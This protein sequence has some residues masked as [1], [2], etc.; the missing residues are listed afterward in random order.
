MRA[1]SS[2][3][4]RRR[5][6]M[7]ASFVLALLFAGLPAS[8]LQAQTDLAKDLLRRG[9]VQRGVCAVV[10]AR[11]DLALDL[12]SASELSVLVREPS[13]QRVRGLRSRAEARGIGIRRLVVDQGP[14]SRLPFADNMVDLVIAAEATEETLRSLS[15]AEVTRA[16]RPEG[17]AIVGSSGSKDGEDGVGAAEL[18]AWAADVAGAQ[19]R[20]DSSGVWIEFRKPPLEGADDWSHWE[21]GPDNNPVS[22]DQV[23]KAPYMTQFLQKPFYIGM[24]SVTTAAGGR[25]FLAIGH[26]AHH[27]REWGGLLRLMARNGYNG[28]VLWE[29]KLP[30]GYLVHRSAFIATRET[31]HMI[32]RDR[33]LLLDPETGREKGEIRIPGLEGDWK[34]MALQDGVLYVL[35][36]K[37]EPGV[38][39]TKGDRSFGGWSWAD[40]S[41]GYYGKR[42]PFGFGDTLVAYDV[43][44]KR[45]LWLHKEESLIDSRGLALGGGRLHFYCP[46][47][48][49][50]ALD[51]KSGDVAWTNGEA[52]VLGLIEMPG[53][54]LI[55]TP[56]FRTAC[57]AVY[58]PK[59]LIIQGQTR[60]N[61]V[62]LSTENGRLLWT[63]KKI[64]NNPNAIFVK[65]NVI[66]GIGEGGSHVSIEPESGRVVEKLMFRKVACTRLTASTDSFF[67]RGEGTLRYDRYFKK[68]FVDG[69]ARP[70]CNDGALPA[71][72]M[73]YIGP[74]QCD[75]NLSLIGALARCSAGEF[76]FDHVATEAERLRR[77]PGNVED[78]VP[79]ETSEGDWPTYRGDNRRGSATSVAVKGSLGPGWRYSPEKPHVPTAPVAAGGLIFSSGEDGVIR[80]V[81]A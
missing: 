72:G 77:T 12:V 41:K 20:K 39:I 51:A 53:H 47:R 48:H 44:A 65:G 5:S 13:R 70:A 73:L 37:P 71:N 67:C 27:R 29:R 25:T 22:T 76:R 75:C 56:G 2:W 58:T 59:A 17:R 31:F 21:H 23:I 40:L 26:I 36:G 9:E 64:T 34:W 79:F 61:V 80:A 69:A 38:E 74:W 1:A 18:K 32:D 6:A 15:A 55:S 10:G 45:R 8:L 50:R 49:L 7:V 30:Q 4:L 46:D 62:A 57:L 43:Q 19:V 60:M 68:V 52:E 81:D 24:P 63:K 14:L 28:T 42:I 11:G 35:A 78:V 54:K 3:E 16:L 66:L 33:C